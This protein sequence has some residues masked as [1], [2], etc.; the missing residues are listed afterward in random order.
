MTLVH[1]VCD[2]PGRTYSGTNTGRE[3]RAGQRGSGI[4]TQELAMG[5]FIQ[6]QQGQGCVWK[7][8]HARPNSTIRDKI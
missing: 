7:G 3:G 5:L 1:S 6:K 8:P 4:E 2:F